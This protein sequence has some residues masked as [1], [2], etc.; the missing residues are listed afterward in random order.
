MA[1]HGTVLEKIAHYCAYQDRCHSEVRYKLIELGVY[2][3][4]LE[5]MI[6]Y[7]ISEKYLDEER[8]AQSFVRGKLKY[9]EWGRNKIIQGLKA[10]QVSE[11]C[12][13][14]GLKE[15]I[16]EEYEQIIWKLIN[17]K[18]ESLPNSDNDWVRKQKILRYLVQRGF[19]MDI[20]GDTY[21][22]YL[23]QLSER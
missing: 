23:K 6:A 17:K 1:K 5:E 4:E 18:Y 22:Q 11:Y 3:D 15:I 13:K 21:D 9:S 10:K 20:V 7:L 16:P 2:G 14:K 8:Y 12:I 19:E